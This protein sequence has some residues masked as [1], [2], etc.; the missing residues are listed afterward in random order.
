MKPPPGM[1]EV[2]EHEATIRDLLPKLKGNA[3][4]RNDAN[5]IMRG[6]P[7]GGT[8]LDHLRRIAKELTEAV[9]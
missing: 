8:R 9:L 5:M 6:Q 4:L 2:Y 7:K 3:E 1:E